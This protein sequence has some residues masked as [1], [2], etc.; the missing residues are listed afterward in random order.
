MKP[1]DFASGGFFIIRESGG[2]RVKIRPYGRKDVSR[3]LEIFNQSQT[4]PV[5]LERFLH[6]D[7]EAEKRGPLV[8]R[9]L[10]TDEGVIAFFEIMKFPVSKKGSLY[11]GIYVDKKR[12]RSPSV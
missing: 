1:S 11:L 10:E 2:I 8:R 3:V 4:I 7:M 6:A 12:I 9:V 5:T